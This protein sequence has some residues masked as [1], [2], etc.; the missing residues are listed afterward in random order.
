MGRVAESDLRRVFGFLGSVRA[1]TPDDPLPRSTLIEL[2]DLLGADEAEYFELGK[3]D[4]A[5]L[6]LT[7]SDD[8]VPAPGTDAAMLAYSGQNPVGWRRFLPEHGAMRLSGRV[9]RNDLNRLGFYGEF[10]APNRL[11]D[12]LKVW[13][14]SDS[15]S[16]ACVQLWRRNRD[17]SRREQ[18]LLGVLQHD[19]IRLRR[20]GLAGATARFAEAGV[21]TAREAEVLIWA[22]RGHS[23]EEIALR[24]GT[25]VGTVGKHLE[26][27]Y[28]TLGVRS[29]AQVVERVLLSGPLDAAPSSDPSHRDPDAGR[30]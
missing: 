8:V 15:R 30:R 14:V 24:L 29:R 9:R 20:L 4:R 2:R 11:R 23:H 16:A 25:S 18:D 13:L 12:I 22:V 26:H 21:L 27:A 10:M 6:A 1:G 7:T 28:A 5:V 3:P 17:F 19:L